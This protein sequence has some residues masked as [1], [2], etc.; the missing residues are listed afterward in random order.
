MRMSGAIFCTVIRMK[1]FHQLNPSITL[2]NHQCRG[3]APLFIKRGVTMM[4]LVKEELINENI[5]SRIDFER[6]FKY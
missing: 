5:L 6:I 1:Q 2:G 3:A 4:T